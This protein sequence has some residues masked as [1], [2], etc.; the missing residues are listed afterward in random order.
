MGPTALV[1]ALQEVADIV[2]RTAS[3][4]TT[5]LLWNKLLPLATSRGLT[6]GGAVDLQYVYTHKHTHALLGSHV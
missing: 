5:E 4:P 2:Y 3:D 1:A 6:D